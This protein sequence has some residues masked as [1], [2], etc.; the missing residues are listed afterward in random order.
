MVS[1]KV[2]TSRNGYLVV[3][4]AEKMLHGF[5]MGNIAFESGYQNYNI[6]VKCLTDETCK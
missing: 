4:N 3:T 6:L 1:N 2:Y 5:V